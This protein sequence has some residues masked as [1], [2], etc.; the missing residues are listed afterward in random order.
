MKV[1]LFA[2]VL[3]ALS[4]AQIRAQTSSEPDWQTIAGGKMSFEVA[5]VRKSVPESAL[6]A[7]FPMGP[8]A[9][10]KDTGGK[11]YAN[12]TLSSYIQFAYKLFLTSEQRTA[13]LARFPAWTR[14]DKFTIMASG[15]AGANKDQMRL[16]MQSLLADRF[17]LKVHFEMREAKVL[18][19]SLEPPGKL[20]PRLHPH[21]VGFPCDKTAPTPSDG[22]VPIV[23][24]LDCDAVVIFFDGKHPPTLGARNMTM[25][26]MAQALMEP[27]HLGR[28]IVDNTG[29]NGRYDF[30][31]TWIPDSPDLPLPD[32]ETSGGPDILQALREQLG[33]KLRPTQVSLE[34][35]VVD[36]VKPLLD[37]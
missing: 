16:M 5:S 25:G 8:D 31:L 22:S 13:L 7:N 1:V 12:F 2:F 20:G 9:I 15:P 17:G 37:N 3:C 6:R 32:N 19:M 29:V 27:S 24:P 30:T 34:E 36:D 23:F 28:P 33:L 14:N 18:A 35:L 4:N 11:L 10:Y 21:R 26:Q